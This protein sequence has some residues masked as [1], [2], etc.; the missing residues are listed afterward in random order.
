MSNENDVK[1]AV[2][3]F[4]IIAVLFGAGKACHGE[5]AYDDWTCGFKNCR[6]IK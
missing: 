4:L 6:A 1:I 2:I 5:W 3:A